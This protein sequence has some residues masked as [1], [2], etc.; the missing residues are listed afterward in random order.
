MQRFAHADDGREPAREGGS[1]LCVYVGVRF[2]VVRPALAVADYDVL[3]SGVLQ[4]RCAHL[5]GVG[6]GGM[7]A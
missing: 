5:A 6:S 3:C 1:E 4:L 7:R 2:A